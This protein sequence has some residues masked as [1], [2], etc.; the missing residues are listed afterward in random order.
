MISEMLT[1]APHVLVQKHSFNPGEQVG[2]HFDKHWHKV[3]YVLE[4]EFEIAVGGGKPK[5]YIVGDFQKVSLGFNY[6]IKS[7]GQSSILEILSG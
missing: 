7:R 3:L 6:S 4:G 2:P 5:V 1:E